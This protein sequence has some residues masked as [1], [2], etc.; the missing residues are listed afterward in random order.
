M[1]LEWPRAEG[2]ERG[3]GAGRG[4]LVC[5]LTAPWPLESTEQS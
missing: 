1:W 2:Q 5:V 4:G 3:L